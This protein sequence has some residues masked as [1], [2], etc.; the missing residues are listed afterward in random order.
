MNGERFRDQVAEAIKQLDRGIANLKRGVPLM[1]NGQIIDT[2][3]FS[4][5]VGIAV[6]LHDYGGGI[7]N[8][9]VLEAA[10][11]YRPGFAIIR[12]IDLMLLAHTLRDM[13]EFIDYLSF[14]QEFLDCSGC[15][16]DE[17]D[18]LAAFL[19]NARRYRHLFKDKPDAS[20]GFFR[21]RGVDPELLIS[22]IAPRGSG[23]WRATV[24]NLEKV[25]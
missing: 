24:A 19:E 15:A 9:R 10:R 18:I 2:T 22:S 17:I 23:R 25:F 21:A 12:A 5:F 7:W 16:M 14:R 1:S 13:D 20:T 8:S 6:V 3:R 11:G 4:S